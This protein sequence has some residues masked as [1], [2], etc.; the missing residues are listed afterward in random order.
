MREFK[1]LK[2]EGLPF[3]YD[4]GLHG[5]EPLVT[6][7]ERERKIVLSYIFPGFY[8]SDDSRTVE[9]VVIPFKQVTIPHTQFLAESGKPLLPSFGRYVQ[10]PDDC[11]Y[12]VTVEPGNP[13]YFEPVLILPAQELLVDGKKI[14]RFEYDKDF[15]RTDRLYPED[16]VEVTG[17]LTIDE[18]RALLIHVR[19]LQYNP[20]RKRLVGF[21]S[22]TVTIHLSPSPG[23]GEPTDTAIDR[24]AYGN[25]F[26]N[27]VRGIGTRVEIPPARAGA[28][29]P[30]GGPEFLIIYHDRFKEPAGKLAYWKTMRGLS[31][32][33]VPLDQVGTTVK[34]IKEYIRKRRR[35]AGSRLQYVLLF[36][37]VEVI[38]SE[39]ITGS[40][41]GHNIT[42]YYYS[43]KE[44]PTRNDQYVLPWLS[45]G[46]I[47]LQTEEQGL[48]V[49]DR[50]ISYERDP[51]KN[52]HY[53]RKMVFAAYF[54]DKGRRDGREDRAYVRTMETIAAHMTGLGFE[55]ERVYVTSNPD[56]REYVD[57]S[58]VPETVRTHLFSEEEATQKLIE[59]VSE[60][61]LLVG[62]R[63]HGSSTG[64][65]HPAF[66]TPHLE[67]IISDTPSVFYSI[68]C[69][70]GRFDLR[71]PR[72]CFAEKLLSMEGGAP[73]LIAATR[74]SHTWLNDDLMK[75]LFDAIWSGI[76]PTFP[77]F[78]ASY[79]VRNNRIGDILNYAR[80]YLPLTLSGGLRH[81]KD[82]LEIYHVIGDPSLE[83]WKECPRA[84]AI[85]TEYRQGYLRIT[86]DC[87]PVGTVLTLWCGSDLVKRLTPTSTY[88]TISLRNTAV[89]SRAREPIVVCFW[90]PGYRFQRIQ[91]STQNSGASS[92]SREK[93]LSNDGS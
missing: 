12:S 61:C 74:P 69:L 3:E 24:K 47:P 79:T 71:R 14:N 88:V 63:D 20:A 18:Y 72:E 48:G 25:F 67:S 66:K 7:E 80:T 5:E 87:C 4:A 65:V 19:P 49:V 44:D 35:A 31:T 64:W 1:S 59:A 50:I 39:K 60:G 70:T 11:R 82:H 2:P 46:R 56:V 81:V 9:G 78:T 75:A 62:H 41:S 26:L 38:P 16:I 86:M 40:P 92:P 68:N 52:L 23:E 89:Y 32:E 10:I 36:G 51:P 15:Y 76:I 17:P 33:V 37:D 53:Y 58:L 27:P 83:I 54:Q 34:A 6:V 85:E 29:L 93:R 22:V 45:V 77:G 21:S 42:D 90:A 8:L 84:N 43:T 13:V 91:V 73:S 55:V 57:G 28:P 30:G